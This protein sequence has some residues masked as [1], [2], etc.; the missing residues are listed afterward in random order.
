[1]NNALNNKTLNSEIETTLIRIGSLGYL[2]LNNKTL[3]SEIE[4]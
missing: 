4:T 3:N 1:M 2:P